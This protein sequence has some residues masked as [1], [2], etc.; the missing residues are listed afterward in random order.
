MFV[1][2]FAIEGEVASRRFRTGPRIMVGSFIICHGIPKEEIQ[3]LK[4]S[5]TERGKLYFWHA[6]ICGVLERPE[7]GAN[8]RD[9]ESRDYDGASVAGL[10]QDVQSSRAIQT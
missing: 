5:H 2:I 7:M 4:H 10:Q 1:E 6:G 3:A 8:L 9:E